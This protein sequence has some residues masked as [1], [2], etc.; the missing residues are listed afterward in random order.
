MVHLLDINKLLNVKKNSEIFCRKDQLLSTSLVLLSVECHPNLVQMR[1]IF[2]KSNATLL[3]NSSL[4]P[5]WQPPS[6]K[7]YLFCIL[8]NQHSIQHCYTISV[9]FLFF[10]NAPVIYTYQRCLNKVAFSIFVYLSFP[11]GLHILKSSKYKSLLK[12]IKKYLNKTH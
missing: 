2:Q 1:L 3:W 12:Y 11:Q 9:V 10:F 7:S 8:R 6:Q 5:A 4:L